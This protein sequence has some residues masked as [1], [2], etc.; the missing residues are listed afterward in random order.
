MIK[1]IA[2]YLTIFIPQK[3]LRRKARRTFVTK[4]Y[5]HKVYKNA[6]HVGKNLVCGTFCVASKNTIIGDNV[7]LSGINI[8]GK[9][10]VTISDHCVIG[11]EVL[12]MT[13][14]HNYKT[15]TRLP[16]S[17]ETS[18]TKDV[19]IDKYVWIG[20]R[21]LI[22][23]GTKIGEGAVIQAGSVVHGE[24]PPCALAGGNP[25]KVFKYRDM[26]HYNKLKEE[27]MFLTIED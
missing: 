13:D 19:F 25:A 14:N 27:K 11:N 4:F 5:G 2:K 3:A 17:D 7:R 23:P 21:V 12:I 10:N 15:G 26:E 8:V 20:S 16:F 18:I 9:G 1:H 6:K 22:L 24:I